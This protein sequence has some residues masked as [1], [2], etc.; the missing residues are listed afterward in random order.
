MHEAYYS[1]KKE[2][3]NIYVNSHPTGFGES[4]CPLF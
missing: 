1:P 2:W 4:I 3:E